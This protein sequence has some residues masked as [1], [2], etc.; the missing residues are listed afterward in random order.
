MNTARLN[1]NLSASAL[2]LFSACERLFEY[3]YVHPRT[4][5]G[6]NSIDQEAEER[7]LQAGQ[8]LHQLLHMAARGLEIDSLAASTPE[9]ARWVRAYASSPYAQTQGEIFS[10]QALMFS[11]GGRKIIAKVDRIIKSGDT[12]T[13]I[14]W[15]TSRRAP[16]AEALRRDWQARIYPLALVEAGT[17]LNGGKP[18]RPSQVET[19][20]V[21]LEPNITRRL[22]FDDARRKESLDTLQTAVES[23]N[24]AEQNGFSATG[25]ATGRCTRPLCQYYSLCHMEAP[26][27]AVV[28]TTP[29]TEV[30]EER[31]ALF[32]EF[33]FDD[34]P[35]IL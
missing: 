6:P 1:P 20:F 32:D 21:Y 7:T 8:R 23:I 10:E 16:N 33:E 3:K 28:E 31:L 35:I 2:G 34:E 30:P 27:P 26:P 18:I 12:W 22:T 19:L 29:P 4:W 5:P 17:V 13:I 11:L 9:T 15:K 25:K 24:R 14:D